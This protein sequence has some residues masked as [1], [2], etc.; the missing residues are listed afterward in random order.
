MN[1][2]SY[3]LILALLSL[4]TSS[5][6]SELE[7]TKKNTKAKEWTFTSSGNTLLRFENET[8]DVRQHRQRLRLIVRAGAQA[9]YGDFRVAGRLSTGVK[10][11]QNIPAITIAKF[12]QQS[13]PANDVFVERLLVSYRTPTLSVTAGKQ[14]WSLA[15]QTD[16]FWDRQL[17][18]IGLQAQY[19]FNPN[20]RGHF[21]VLKPLDGAT[22]TVGTLFLVQWESKINMA[23]GTLIF[24]PWWV[25][26]QGQNNA[27]YARRDTQHDHQSI[28]LST[29]YQ[30]GLWRIGA[31]LGYAFDNPDIDGESAQNQSV[32]LQLVY[33]KLVKQFDYQAHLRFFHTEQYSVISEFAQNATAGFATTNIKGLDTRVR[34][35]IKSNIWLG[36]RYSQVATLVG[37]AERGRRFR[38]ET[39]IKF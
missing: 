39:A 5:M 20:H 22:D 17:N 14:P 35:N 3:L 8:F 28:R 18:P 7:L 15:N 26:Y 25:G 38:I 11:K 1:S 27:Q 23:D 19:T 31:D 24:A 13:Q 9:H 33:G 29:A 12:N 32:V 10:N 4:S 21:S 16:T 37:S 36:M 6:A 30:S 2:S 34:Y